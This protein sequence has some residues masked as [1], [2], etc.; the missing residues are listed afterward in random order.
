M[1]EET[2]GVQE[3]RVKEVPLAD[4]S[5]GVQATAIPMEDPLQKYKAVADAPEGEDYKLDNMLDTPLSMDKIAFE[6]YMAAADITKDHIELR[7]TA[8]EQFIN[9]LCEDAETNIPGFKRLFQ[10]KPDPEFLPENNTR[11]PWSIYS[12]WTPGEFS[13]RHFE[14]YPSGIYGIVPGSIPEVVVLC[15][16]PVNP[17]Y[18]VN[19]TTGAV[20]AVVETNDYKFRV[21]HVGF[22]SKCQKVGAFRTCVHLI[23]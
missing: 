22:G 13:S 19:N 12:R 15:E 2:K 23:D 17:V 16:R 10:G 4:G 3:E 6:E 14:L 18:F 20:F 1:T 8:R 11:S 9:R 21:L 5:V 7:D